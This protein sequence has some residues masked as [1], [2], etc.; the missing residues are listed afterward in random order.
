MLLVFISGSFGLELFLRLVVQLDV[1]DGDVV[2][3]GGVGLL[4]EV[5]GT[6]GVELR[7]RLELVGA[8]GARERVRDELFERAVVELADVHRVAL[9]RWVERKHRR[10]AAVERELRVD[11]R[12]LE[13]GVPEERGAPSELLGQLV[14]K[15]LVARLA[16]LVVRGV[17]DGDKADGVLA[18]AAVLEVLRAHDARHFRGNWEA[19]LEALDD[20]RSGF[21]LAELRGEEGEQVGVVDGAGVLHGSSLFRHHDDRR[22]VGNLEVLND[23]FL[24]L[25]DQEKFGAVLEVQGKGSEECWGCALL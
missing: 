21:R 2:V 20:K 18:R 14:D 17:Q 22:E 3:I 4:E 9:A 5:F 13:R 16:V 24:V 15:L 8:D 1:V 23:R 11:V 19:E 6:D 12:L 25:L 7:E 10:E